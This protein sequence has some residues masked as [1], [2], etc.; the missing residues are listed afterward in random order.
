MTP[1][2]QT[3]QK[4]RTGRAS[5]GELAVTLLVSDRAST[6]ASAVRQVATWSE[7]G[8]GSSTVG[9]PVT[10]TAGSSARPAGQ[11]GRVGLRVAG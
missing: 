7:M 1:V 3:P 10:A 2:C 9:W 6:A 5:E 4:G 8:E 11:A